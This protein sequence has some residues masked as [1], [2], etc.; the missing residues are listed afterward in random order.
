MSSH[1]VACITREKHLEHM[2]RIVP[3][4]SMIYIFQCFLFSRFE[5]DIIGPNALLIMGV[6][7]AFMISCIYFYNTQHQVIFYEDHLEMSFLFLHKKIMYSEIKAIH[8]TEEDLNFSTLVLELKSRDTFA[9]FFVDEAKKVKKWLEKQ[10]A[11]VQTDQKA[12]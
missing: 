12:A 3:F 11:Q 2:G 10:S 9:I 7:L 8:T 4:I 6:S 5:M 1:F